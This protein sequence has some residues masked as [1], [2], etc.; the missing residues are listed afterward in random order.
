[1]SLIKYVTQFPSGSGGSFPRHFC[2]DLADL[3]QCTAL[4]K[5][6]IEMWQE[7]PQSATCS[8]ILTRSDQ[9]HYSTPEKNATWRSKCNHNVAICTCS[10]SFDTLHV[11]KD[12]ALCS[13]LSLTSMSLT[14]SDD[15]PLMA[16]LTV[17]ALSPVW[18]QNH[19]KQKSAKWRTNCTVSDCQHWCQDLNGYEKYRSSADWI[20]RY[21]KHRNQ[22][23]RFYH[24]VYCKVMAT[25]GAPSP[26]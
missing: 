18:G 12:W 23:W 11:L 26:T 14:P 15:T 25:T 6:C 7:A 22:T 3:A 10:M 1:M 2:F 21:P 13:A 16:L 9:I 8:M 5:C 4:D 24:V 20:G 17:D 19:W